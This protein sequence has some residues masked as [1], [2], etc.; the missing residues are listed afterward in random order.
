M[1]YDVR[2][3]STMDKVLPRGGVLEA[4]VLRRLSAF[5]GQRVSF[6]AA[7]TYHGFRHIDQTLTQ[8]PRNPYAR[9]HAEG[10][11]PGKIEIRRVECVP[12]GYPA[13]K[14]PEHFDEEYLGLEAGLYPDLL[15]PLGGD[16][17]SGIGEAARVAIRGGIHLVPDQWRSL[18]VDCLIP[19]DAPGGDYCVTLV[20]TDVMGGDG[21]RASIT[22]HVVP[23]ALPPQRILHTEWFYPDCLADYYACGVYTE[24]HWRIIEAFLSKAHERGINMVFTPILTPALDNYIG[25]YRRT[26]QLV[27]ITK[28]GDTYGFDFSRLRRWIALCRKI[29]FDWFEIS[30]LFSQWGAK[31]P[32]KVEAV[33]DGERKVIFGWDTPLEESGY[34]AFLDVFLPKLLQVLREEDVLDRS[35][36]HISDEP[37]PGNAAGYRR[38]YEMVSR[39]LAGLPIIDALSDVELY[40]EGVVPKPIPTN[41]AIHDFLD[42][43]LTD[44]WVYYCCGEGYLASNRFI[45]M[46]GWRTRILGVQ[47][48]RYPMQ[49]FLHWGFN[50]YYSQYS[51]RLIDPFR[52]TD[53]DDGFQAGDPFV[54]Y[55]GK[56]GEPLESLRLLLIEDAMLD[57]RELDLLESLAGRE[58][59]VALVDGLAGRQIRFDDYPKGSWYL[60]QLWESA[61]KEIE[62]RLQV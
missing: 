6:Q 58:F 56:D 14:V 20:F 44:A 46:P 35:Y 41:L 30:H 36:F 10:N 39:H 43:R 47:L 29:G 21:A 27:E 13:E 23:A 31:Y 18:W 22:I 53:A 52:C 45:A 1:G 7:Y 55:P 40:T 51:L 60:Q 32:P 25:T 57:V 54:V 33:A 50:Y 19:E 48:Y 34:G 15:T 59:T 37:V 26:V 28:D 5:R 24:E 9:V 8:A 12:V 61:A 17:R 11:F 38:A 62:R 2:I 3:I 4:S 42:K 49:G 16:L